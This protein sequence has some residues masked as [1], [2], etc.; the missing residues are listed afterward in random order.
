MFRDFF[1]RRK[2]R[3]IGFGEPSIHWTDVDCHTLYS[4]VFYENDNGKRKYTI[5]SQNSIG[6]FELTK[7]YIHCETWKRTGLLPGWVKD[8]IAEKLIR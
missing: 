5:E 8:P 1:K 7:Q 4:I 2:M 3:V 6:S